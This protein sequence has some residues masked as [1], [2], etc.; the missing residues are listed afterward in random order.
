MLWVARRALTNVFMYVQT[1]TQRHAQRATHSVKWAE[2]H[3]SPSPGWGFAVFVADRAKSCPINA[4]AILA[5]RC[6][7]KYTSMYD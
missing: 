2:H 6:G 1:L 7:A 4:L 3:Q 5:L